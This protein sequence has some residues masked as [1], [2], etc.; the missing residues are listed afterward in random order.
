VTCETFPTELALAAALA[1]RLAASI[2]HHP[3]LVLGLPTG[4]TPLALYAELVRLTSSDALDW[5]QVCTFNLDEFRGLGKGDP[6]SY[7]T[8]MDH[9]LF[10]HVNLDERHIHFL[11]GRAPDLARE[12]DRY[13]RAVVQA[14]GLDVLILGIGANGHIGFNEPA[15]ALCA[16]THVATLDGPSRAANA[17]WFGGQI[18]QVPTEALTMGMANILQARAIVLIATG[19]AKSAAVTA[20]L[21]GEV[22]TRVPASFLQL[23]PQVTVML[24]APLAEGRACGA[25]H[26]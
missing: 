22:T 15:D 7:R 14:G 24:D 6:G 18:E 17:L 21:E 11:D 20:M 25:I 2:R 3:R 12:C 19:E 13:E 26:P 4:R 1:R 23:H 8:F 9:R 10:S 16:R 5:S